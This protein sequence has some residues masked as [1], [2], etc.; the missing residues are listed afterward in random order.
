MGPGRDAVVPGGKSLCVNIPPPTPTPMLSHRFGASW[1]ASK[2]AVPF[3][4]DSGFSSAESNPVQGGLLAARGGSLV[5]L[6]VLLSSRSWLVGFLWA[7]PAARLLCTDQRVYTRVWNV[8]NAG[9][10]L[11][12]NMG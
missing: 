7:G 1:T 10:A 2:G 9:K 3:E 12:K 8:L 6:A 5:S 11:G 4:R